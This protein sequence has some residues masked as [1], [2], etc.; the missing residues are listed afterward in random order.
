MILWL[1]AQILEDRLLPVTLHMIPIVNHS[2]SDGIVDAVAWR[3]G[4][5]EGFIADEEVEVLNTPFRC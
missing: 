4:V 3:L 1:R 2:M 5:G